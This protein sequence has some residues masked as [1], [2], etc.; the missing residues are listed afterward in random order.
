MHAI[1]VAIFILKNGSQVPPLASVSGVWPM[2][3][4]ENEL[5]F[6]VLRVRTPERQVRP[7]SC[8]IATP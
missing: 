1:L 6:Y 2:V 3:Q 7:V 4:R 8:L 5:S